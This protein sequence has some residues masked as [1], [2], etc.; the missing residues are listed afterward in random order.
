MKEYPINY[1]VLPVSRTRT[2][3][4]RLLSVFV[5]SLI[6]VVSFLQGGKEQLYGILLF[7]ILL[8]SATIVTVAAVRLKN[9]GNINK[10][11]FSLHRDKLLVKNDFLNIIEYP[12]AVYN[13]SV[14]VNKQLFEWFIDVDGMKPIH[15][16]S[17]EDKTRHQLI[18]ELKALVEHRNQ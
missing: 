4:I 16:V 6:F 15:I 12:L 9:R 8:V 10:P 11:K 13:E 7:F 2:T 14:V 3:L 18:N 1:D 17:L 5:I